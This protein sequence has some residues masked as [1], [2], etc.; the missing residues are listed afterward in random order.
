MLIPSINC[1]LKDIS[2]FQLIKRRLYFFV[3]SYFRL[4][5]SIRLKIWKPKVI[6]VTGSSGKTTLLHLIESQLGSAA[7]YSHEANSSFGI[8]FNILGLHRKT[9]IITEWL[10][11]FIL[12]PFKVFSKIPREK[13]YVVEADC[14][15]PHEGI[16]LSKLLKS[17][18]TLW[19]NVSR[20]HATN[21][22]KE[23]KNG[24]FKNV[25][26]AIAYEFGYFAETARDLVIIGDASSLLEKQYSR[27]KCS[28]Q[29]VLDSY[30]LSS[31]EVDEKG[32]TFVINK[33]NYNFKYLLPR[34]TSTLISMCLTLMDYLGKDVDKTF[35]NFKLAPGRSSVFEGIKDITI[36][37]STYNANLD[38]MTEIVEMFSKI[39]NGNKWAVLGDMIEQG[40][41]EEEEHTK[42]GR[43]L[44]KY[45]FQKFILMG[46][47][48][49][50]YTK[51]VLLGNKRDVVSFLGPK[52]V[53][54]YLA[55]NIKGGELILFKGAR[56]L[57]GVIEHLLKNKSDAGKL[58][59]REKI[60]EIRRKKWEL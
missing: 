40:S 16:F 3:A 11:L 25:D 31:Y 24:K 15:R 44:L 10:M 59:R 35:N 20:T 33:G 6:V 23:V 39:K 27:I 32:S 30:D 46:P 38:S 37:D 21:F 49:S 12:A 36:I 41:H 29:K 47:R 13:F 54:D 1:I 45:D 14:D 28:M 58:A 42:L 43:L 19:T 53:L 52:E 55:K 8:P 5:A 51:A 60:W 9:L 34:K 57:E 4:F 26:E 2:M 17:E 56:F 50:K 48:V 22:E 7:R 18:I